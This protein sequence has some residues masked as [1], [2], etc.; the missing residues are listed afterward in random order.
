MISLLVVPT[1]D[2]NKSPANKDTMTSTKKGP[3]QKKA[4]NGV[5]QGIF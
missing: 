5:E 3:N 4:M 1:S 2:Q